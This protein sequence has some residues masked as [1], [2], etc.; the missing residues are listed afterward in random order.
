MN[1]YS[2]LN[3][4]NRTPIMAFFTLIIALGGGRRAVA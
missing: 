3:P 1:D 4:I 2:I